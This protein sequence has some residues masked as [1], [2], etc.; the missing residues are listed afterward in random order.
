MKHIVGFLLIQIILLSNIL[1][2]D[3]SK[4]E[5]QTYFKPQDLIYPSKIDY[6]DIIIPNDYSSKLF[7]ENKNYPIK[8]IEKKLRIKLLHNKNI[9]SAYFKAD[10]IKSKDNKIAKI[11]FENINKNKKDIVNIP[12]C[13]IIN[14]KYSDKE[15]REY[16]DIIEN[17]NIINYYIKSLNTNAVIMS[18]K[19][20]NT[21]PMLATFSY[22][23]II[24]E[25]Y[26]SKDNNTLEDLYNILDAFYK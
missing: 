14:T 10:Y 11:I 22:N 12:L 2:I 8:T 7:Q 21:G 4:N 20:N 15:D 3:E 24:Y 13:I 26:M 25:L 16:L 5:K 23:N 19:E 18:S 6:S 9:D 17:S 1:L